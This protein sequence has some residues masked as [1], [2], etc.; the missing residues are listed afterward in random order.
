MNNCEAAV[1]PSQGYGG[2]A[3]ISFEKQRQGFK[4]VIGK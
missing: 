3:R 2:Q 1:P 4:T